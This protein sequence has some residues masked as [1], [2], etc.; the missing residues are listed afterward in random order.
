VS[1]VLALAILAVASGCGEQQVVLFT[2]DSAFGTD[3]SVDSTPVEVMDR[4]PENCGATMT[5]CQDDEYCV[6]GTC[7]CRQG[8]VPG[9]EDGCIDLASDA[10]SCGATG[11]SCPSLCSGGACVTSCPAGTTE[12]EGGCVDTSSHPLH[13]GECERRCGAGRVCADGVCVPFRPA[14][15]VSCPCD[16]CG[17]RTCCTYPTTT[18]PICVDGPSCPADF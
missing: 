18:D 13:C 5:H 10:E 1:L 12:C 14:A 8:L 9:E 16:L 7:V 3:G 6:S 2:S 4:D 15:C 17:T 11:T